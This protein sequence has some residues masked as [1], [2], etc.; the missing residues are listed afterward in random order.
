MFFTVFA[1]LAGL[2]IVWGASQAKDRPTHDRLIDNDVE[3]RIVA[4][5]LAM[6]VVML[7]MVADRINYY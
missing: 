1:S 4:C 7:G 6:I 5:L 2:L 3:M